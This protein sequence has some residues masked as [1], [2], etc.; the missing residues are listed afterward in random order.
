MAR[1]S[2]WPT[3]TRP[4]SRPSRTTTGTWPAS[5]TRATTPGNGAGPAATAGPQPVVVTINPVADTPSITSATT[6]EDTQSGTGLVI[7]RNS[8]DR[9]EVTHFQITGLH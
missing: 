6:D 3:V 2:Y 5:P 7:S 1:S 8:A 4:G 9:A